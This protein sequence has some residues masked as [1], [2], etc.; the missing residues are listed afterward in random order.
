MP[1]SAFILICIAIGLE[2]VAQTSFKR[3]ALS[4]AKLP[5]E[6]G[7]GE[8]LGRI[9]RNNW[10]LVGILAYALEVP[11]CVAALTLAPLS[12]VFPMLSLSYCGVAL[13]GWLFFG[14]RLILRQQVAIL[15]ITVGAGLVSL[16]G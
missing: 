5:Q 10:I 7:V 16:R 2:V 8:Y 9:A 14:E 1:L 3:G 15:M 6:R 12:V 13:A 4:T 11:L